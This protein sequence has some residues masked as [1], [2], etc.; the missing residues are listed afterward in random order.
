MNDDLNM[1]SKGPYIKYVVRMGGGGGGV[2]EFCRNQK[3][4]Y[5]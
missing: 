4:F 3:I 1:L 2:E 5:A